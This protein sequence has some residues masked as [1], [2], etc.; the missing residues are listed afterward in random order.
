MAPSAGANRWSFFEQEV[1]HRPQSSS[2]S[3]LT[4]RVLSILAL[5]PVARTSGPPGHRKVELLPPHFLTGIGK[6]KC[7]TEVSDGGQYY[8]HYQVVCDGSA[9]ICLADRPCTGPTAQHNR[10]ATTI[11]HPD[12]RRSPAPITDTITA[13]TTRHWGCCANPFA[14]TSITAVNVGIH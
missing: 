2:A 8:E 3:R 4:R 10:P 7:C 5:D 11:N 12:T 13:A 9:W 1:G 14:H 6:G